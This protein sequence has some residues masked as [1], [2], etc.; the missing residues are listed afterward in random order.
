MSKKWEMW[1]PASDYVGGKRDKLHLV[2]FY[3]IGSEYYQYYCYHCEISS[4]IPLHFTKD[5]HE[6]FRGLISC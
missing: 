2:K 6:L 5:D 4:T 3:T 1:M